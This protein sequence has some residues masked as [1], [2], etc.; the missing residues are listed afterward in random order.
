MQ[1]SPSRNYPTACLGRYGGVQM[2]MRQRFA[3]ANDAQSSDA[4]RDSI[5]P[6]TFPLSESGPCASRIQCVSQSWLAFPS[7]P[8][9]LFFPFPITLTTTDKLFSLSNSFLPPPIEATDCAENAC[10]RRRDPFFT[11]RP[12]E[13]PPFPPRTVD[14]PSHDPSVRKHTPSE[15]YQSR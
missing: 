5:C 4:S 10:H 13:R 12:P 1:R 9:K 6:A 15:T 2:S 11:N 3:T 8:H 14:T 7:V